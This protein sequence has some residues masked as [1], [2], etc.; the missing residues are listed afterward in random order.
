MAGA[1]HPGDQAG[2][3]DAVHHLGEHG[4]V[5]AELN[6]E[7][8]ESEDAD[9]QRE[10]TNAFVGAPVACLQLRQNLFRRGKGFGVGGIE[11]VRERLKEVRS[12]MASGGSWA[13]SARSRR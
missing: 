1:K 13:I 11:P 12:G 10:R 2:G 3:N 7:I 6:L 8:V 4:R 9:A 5:L